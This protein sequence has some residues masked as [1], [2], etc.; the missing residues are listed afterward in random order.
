MIFRDRFS[1][2]V[3]STLSGLN[4]LLLVS[5]WKVSPY[6]AKSSTLSWLCIFKPFVPNAPLLYLQKTSEKIARYLLGQPICCQCTHFLP[7]LVHKDDIRVYTSHIRITYK[8]I[9]VT[10]GWHTCTYEWHTDDMR[11]HTNDMRMTY[12][13]HTNEV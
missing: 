9:Q 12:V 5:L 8:W 10:Y 11:V 3:N 6:F 1:F 2:I 4:S 13:L 7:I